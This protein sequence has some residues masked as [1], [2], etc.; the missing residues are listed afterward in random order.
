[1]D[2]TTRRR[3]ALE[4][5]YGPLEDSIDPARRVGW[6]SSAAQRLRLETLVS[7][8]G[9]ALGGVGSVVDAGCGEGALIEVLRR[10]GFAGHYR[11]EDLRQGPIERARANTAAEW[12]VADS[13]VGGEPDTDIVFCS[14]A[15]N[16]DSGREDH[17]AEV[18]SAVAALFG[19]ARV[20]LVFD[21]AVADRHHPGVLLVAADLPKLYAFCRG[22]TPIV[23]VHEDTLVGEAV[24]A[25]WRSRSFAFARRSDTPVLAA[26]NL[27]LAGEADASLRVVGVDASARAGRIRGQALTALGRLEEAR[28]ALSEVAAGEDPVEATRAALLQAPLLWRAGRRVEA[29]ALLTRLARHDDDARAHLFE[30]QL[31]RRQHDLARTTALAV[32]DPWMRRELLRILAER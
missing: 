7:V 9:P 23:S 6:E 25:L 22:L 17:Q 1:M 27:L 29:E 5:F 30:L 13:F 20:G 12:V 18:E 10:R 31:A 4:G 19:R 14:G 15:L 24:I 16:T 26:E 32:T 8:A 11:G 3:A 2:D 28:A 21:I